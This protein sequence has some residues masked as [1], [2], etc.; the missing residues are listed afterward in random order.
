MFGENLTLGIII[1]AALLDSINPCVI[2]VLVFLIAFMTRVFKNR[3]RMLIGSLLYALV[4]YA[5]YLVIGLGILR[6]TLSIDAATTFYW[7]VALIAI[8][9]G[10]LEIKDFFWYGKGFSLQIIPGASARIKSYTQWI[11]RL[12]SR[13][14]GILLLTMVVL[15]IFVVLVELPCTGAPYLAVLGLLSQGAY[16]QALPLLLLYNFVFIIPLLIIIGIAYFGTSSERLE[17]WRQAHKGLMRLVV[18]VFLIV[19]GFYMIY[20]LNPVL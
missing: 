18:G 14:F 15:G 8:F 19:L 3:N 11:E 20:S 9:A 7:I 1:G 13:H 4:V 5:S 2:G 12:E 17:A 10:F 16:A 6:F